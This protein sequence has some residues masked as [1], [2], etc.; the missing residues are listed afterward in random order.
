VDN[1]ENL[2][3]AVTAAT[4]GA[5][6]DVAAADSKVVCLKATA[7]DGTTSLWYKIAV[8]IFTPTAWPAAANTVF[9]V[10]AISGGYAKLRVKSGD[11]FGAAAHGCCGQTCHSEGGL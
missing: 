5:A 7:E 9:R 8:E 11:T 10:E 4:F 6:L 3:P 2:A 1:V